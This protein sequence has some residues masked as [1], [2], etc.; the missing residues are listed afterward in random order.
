MQVDIRRWTK[1]A[2]GLA[3]VE[4]QAVFC[5]GGILWQGWQGAVIRVNQQ[6]LTNDEMSR[7]RDIDGS[8]DQVWEQRRASL[9]GRYV[10]KSNEYD[11][12]RAKLRHERNAIRDSMKA[13]REMDIPQNPA[14]LSQIKRIDERMKRLELLSMEE[15]IHAARFASKEE[16]VPAEPIVVPPVVQDHVPL[17]CGEPDCDYTTPRDKIPERAMRGHMMGKHRKPFPR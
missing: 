5:V 17:A 3:V 8:V 4:S 9:E 1:T 6:H 14:D 15:D 12:R 10:R 13:D 11:E 2:D 7:I 16:A